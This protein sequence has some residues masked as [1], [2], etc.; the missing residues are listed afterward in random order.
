MTIKKV[1]HVQYFDEKGMEFT[2]EPVEDTL[3]IKKT[4]DGYEARYLVQDENY[5]DDWD[6]GDDS[7]F[8]VNYHRDFWVERKGVISEDDLRSLYVEGKCDQQKD[9][10]IFPMACLIHSGVWLSLARAF[11]CDSGGWDTSHVGAVLCA[12]AVYKTEKR[13]E[14]AAESL[15]DEKNKVLSNEVYGIV[16]D[17]YDGEKK[18]ID[19]KSV[20]GFIG[21]DY[22]KKELET[23]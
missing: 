19:N 1:T 11:A 4:K 10:F 8:L 7:L 15:I 20:W 9:Y 16:K 21:F 5:Q 22:A 23:F 3:S 13:A 17:V 18:L 14:K 6:E 12:K 2:F